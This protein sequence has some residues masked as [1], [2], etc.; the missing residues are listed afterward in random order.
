MTF[1]E[2]QARAMETAVYPDMGR[3]VYPALGLA[4]ETGE[5][6]DKIKKIHRDQCGAISAK[7]LTALAM[8]MGDVMWYLAALAQDFELNLSEVAQ[9]NLR[10]LRDRQLRGVI[11]GS[12]DNR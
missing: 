12:G 7:Q 10:K 2:Y 3:G 6:V 11:R 4:G 8:E 1:D 5:L 9:D